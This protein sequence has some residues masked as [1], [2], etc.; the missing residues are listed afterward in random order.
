MKLES[1][2]YKY[3]LLTVAFAC[4]AAQ[5]CFAQIEFTEHTIAGD[6][7]GARSVY[8][9][10][11]DGDGDMDVLGAAYDAHDIT[12]WENDGEQEF[13]EHTIAD[14][15]EWAVSVY[16]ADVDGDDDIDVLGTA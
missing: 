4:V 16:A 5:V 7:N 13:T 11:L 14:N 15:Y 3:Y 9:T 10:D 12:W 2:Y 1:K 8:A 6:F